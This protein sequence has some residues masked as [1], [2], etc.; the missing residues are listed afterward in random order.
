M[1][2]YTGGYKYIFYTLNENVCNV[3]GKPYIETEVS[4]HR[5]ETDAS[6]KITQE[7]NSYT[8]EKVWFYS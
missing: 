6:F 2:V 5:R 1:L 3:I 7:I 4:F 8:V